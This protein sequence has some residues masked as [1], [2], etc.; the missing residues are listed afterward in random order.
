MSRPFPVSLLGEKEVES[1]LTVEEVAK[2]AGIAPTTV[3][4]WVS[5]KRLI[6]KVSG[7]RGTGNGYRFTKDQ[8]L[9]LKRIIE[10]RH[11][12]ETTVI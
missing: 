9:K 5:R 3:L 2:V 12:V 4:A 8:A 1:L 7:G 10:L 11:E 6:P